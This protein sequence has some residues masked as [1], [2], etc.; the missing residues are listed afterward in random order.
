MCRVGGS[1]TEDWRGLGVGKGSSME[2]ESGTA[3]TKNRHAVWQP[4]PWGKRN[5]LFRNEIKTSGDKMLKNY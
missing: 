5:K 1:Y 3:L 2:E 4:E